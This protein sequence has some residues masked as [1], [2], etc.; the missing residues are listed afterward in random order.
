MTLW[1]TAFFG[2]AFE[3]KLSEKKRFETQFLPFSV[4]SWNDSRNEIC[5][6]LL[7]NCNFSILSTLLCGLR[8]SGVQSWNKPTKTT[9]KSIVW[10]WPSRLKCHPFDRKL[11]T[12]GNW[13]LK[14]MDGDMILLQTHSYFSVWCE[15]KDVSFTNTQLLSSRHATLKKPRDCEIIFMKINLRPNSSKCSQQKM[16][17]DFDWIL[18]L[19]FT[20]IHFSL[21]TENNFSFQ[22]KTIFVFNENH[23]LFSSQNIFRFHPNLFFGV[24]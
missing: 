13:R 10:L 5:P 24:N 4:V 21:S 2:K 23:F 17:I 3:G 15:S 16:M 19:V 11:E 7:R 14:W 18:F 6:P 12:I 1:R 9:P 8:K 22:Q 20:K